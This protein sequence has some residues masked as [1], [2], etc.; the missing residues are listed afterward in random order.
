MRNR[1]IPFLLPGQKGLQMLGYH[2]IEWIFFRIPGTIFG[3]GITDGETF[4]FVIRAAA[5]QG[6]LCN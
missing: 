5:G 2:A 4:I 1:A 3:F 6:N